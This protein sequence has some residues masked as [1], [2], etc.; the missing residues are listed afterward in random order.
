[1]YYNNPQDLMDR[2]ELFGGSIL[3]GNDGGKY[4]FTQIAHVLNKIG[5]LNNDHLRNLSKECVIYY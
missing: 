1:M 3:V 2:L 4:E 5:I